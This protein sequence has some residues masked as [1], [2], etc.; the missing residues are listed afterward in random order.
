MGVLSFGECEEAH[1]ELMKVG[2]VTNFLCVERDRWLT[3]V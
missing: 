3:L 1:A 2:G